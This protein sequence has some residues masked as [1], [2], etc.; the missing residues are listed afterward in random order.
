[1][2]MVE[3]KD[4]CIHLQPL[5]ALA[6]FYRIRKQSKTIMPVKKIIPVLNRK[7]QIIDA[8]GRPN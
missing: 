8:G 4:I 6:I 5:M 3:H 1:M 7:S 2:N